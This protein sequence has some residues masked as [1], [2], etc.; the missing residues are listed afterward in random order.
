MGSHRERRLG[1][2]MGWVIK[3][4]VLQAGRAEGKRSGMGLVN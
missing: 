3:R 1:Q 4:L 2:V